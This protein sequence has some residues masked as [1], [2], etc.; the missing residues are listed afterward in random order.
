MSRAETSLRP[1]MSRVSLERRPITEMNL[2]GGIIRDE[3]HLDNLITYSYLN[4][5]KFEAYLALRLTNL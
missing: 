4:T 5:A 1:H 3:K 2:V